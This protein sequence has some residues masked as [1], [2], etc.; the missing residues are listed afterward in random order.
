VVALSPYLTSRLNF[1]DVSAD[2]EVVEAF[3]KGCFVGQRLVVA[4][5]QMVKEGN[6]IKQITVSRAAVEAVANSADKLFDVTGSAYANTANAAAAPA[7]ASAKAARQR[8]SEAQEQL[9]QYESPEYEEGQVVTALL[10]LCSSRVPKPP[11]V[12]LSLPGHRLGRVCATELWDRD[13]WM[14]LSD[15]YRKQQQQHDQQEEDRMASLCLPDGRT[16]GQVVQARVLSVADHC[17]ELSLR[18][19]RVVRTLTIFIVIIIFYCLHLFFIYLFFKFCSWHFHFLL[20]CIRLGFYVTVLK[21]LTNVFDK[22]LM[23]Y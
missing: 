6:K 4:V 1:I 10:N 3:A 17:V 8:Y 23:L 14:D 2:A 9:T 21:K 18:P 5:T 16:H 20:L 7:S 19:S 13:D 22:N 12:V 11:A 15:F